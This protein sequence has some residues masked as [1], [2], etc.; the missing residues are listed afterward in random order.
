MTYTKKKLK[1]AQF[2]DKIHI[3]LTRISLKLIEE[4]VTFSHKTQTNK[5]A[6]VCVNCFYSLESSISN[7]TNIHQSPLGSTVKWLVS[8]EASQL[9]LPKCKSSADWTVSLLNL[10]SLFVWHSLCGGSFSPSLCQ[11]TGTVASAAAQSSAKGFPASI[12]FVPSTSALGEAGFA[13]GKN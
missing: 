12:D 1:K 7:S 8:S 11:Q 10:P 6:F 2:K 9:Y 5:D 13:S 4:T 3:L